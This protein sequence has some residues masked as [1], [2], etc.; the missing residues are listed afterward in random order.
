[1]ATLFLDGQP[2]SPGQLI[3]TEPWRQ[4][5]WLGWSRAEDRPAQVV[6]GGA[7]VQ[8]P[9]EDKGRLPL[10]LLAGELRWRDVGG[11][12]VSRLTLPDHTRPADSDTW[13]LGQFA[14]A[15]GS[16]LSDSTLPVERVDA[17]P[18]FVQDSL[19]D[20]F[21]QTA[22]DRLLAS[23]L[24]SLAALCARPRS[25]LREEEIMQPIGRV[26]R[27]SRRA[28]HA[29]ARHPEHVAVNRLRVRPQRLL[30]VVQEE[31]LELYENR[32]AL[33][34]IR[35]LQA[36]ARRR[37]ARV[38]K[39]MEQLDEITAQIERTLRYGHYRRAR[40]LR[41][42]VGIDEAH[43]ADIHDKGQRIRDAF[44]LQLR[45]FS[46]CLSSRLGR[47]LR[48]SAP[49]HGELR[50][51]NILVHDR[52]YRVIEPLWR[53]MQQEKRARGAKHPRLDDPEAAFAD[54][55]ML[56]AARALWELGYQPEPGA[57]FLLATAPDTDQ[58]SQHERQL[59]FFL[60]DPDQ[61]LPWAQPPPQQ[62]Q[63]P[64]KSK[65][66]KDRRRRRRRRPNQQAQD[67]QQLELPTG[68]RAL[69]TR[70][71]GGLRLADSCTLALARLDE[72]GKEHHT[73]LLDLH[74]TFTGLPDR[75]DLATRGSDGNGGS[76]PAWL[77]P[78]ELV[79]APEEE[80]SEPISFT[81]TLVRHSVG[82][83]PHHDGSAP[84]D[85]AIPV[86]PWLFHS[87]DRMARLLL[88]RT[89]GT[90][91]RS[92]RVPEQCPVCGSPGRSTRREGDRTCS[93]TECGTQW[94]IRRCDCGTMIPKVLPPLPRQEVLEK[95][96]A[97]M[98]T[99]LARRHLMET[100]GGRELLADLCY[101]DQVMSTGQFWVICP[102]CGHCHERESCGESCV[103]CS[104]TQ[105]S[106]R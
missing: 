10:P 43:L 78:I 52:N 77:H 26:R 62:H 79:S 21:D 2:V 37:L 55:T 58:T 102:G 97:A 65:N 44:R 87:T 25:W 24:A 101:S 39:A 17:L 3:I 92:G 61:P 9:R 45:T 68:W 60:P 59:H 46:A 85:I 84:E 56:L 57:S 36:R 99:P 31:E 80:A 32:A 94:G 98:T 76:Q 49:V 48:D 75:P 67:R 29:M 82:F 4:H 83:V 89:L 8:V 11:R 74:S 103:R 27:V 95:A 14:R 71:T 13:F 34:L 1:M 72:R 100:L 41:T 5:L 88:T 47:S 15:L 73:T 91:M 33:T 93:D 104:G 66:Q 38:E 53:A 42:R 70:R 6:V 69:L 20:Q 7:P 64:S 18:L 81:E 16:H 54:F 86:A 28:I 40:K 19:L 51:T 35:A 30:A 22:L 106:K 63:E 96:A 12:Q 23:S 50:S 90:D 105:S